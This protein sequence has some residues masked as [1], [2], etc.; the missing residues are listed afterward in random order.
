MRPHPPSALVVTV[1]L[2]DRIFSLNIETK[3]L[4]I[5]QKI[6]KKKKILRMW[7]I[8]EQKFLVAYCPWTGKR[9]IHTNRQGH[10]ASRYKRFLFKI[11]SHF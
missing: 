10:I 11:Y 4:R 2:L 7:K 1:G 6:K 9:F 5:F 3:I 8:I